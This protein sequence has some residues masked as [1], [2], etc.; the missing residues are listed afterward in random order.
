MENVNLHSS[1]LSIEGELELGIILNDPVEKKKFR[2]IAAEFKLEEAVDL[3]IR[4]NLE[5][6][7]IN[8][9]KRYFRSFSYYDIFLSFFAHS[10]RSINDTFGKSNSWNT[11]PKHVCVH[12]S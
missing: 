10:K 3:L 8:N 5:K 4:I 7:I 6:T 2:I 9:Y 11:L 12:Y 1:D